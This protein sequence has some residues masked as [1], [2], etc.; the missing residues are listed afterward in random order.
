M[1]DAGAPCPKSKLSLNDNILDHPRINNNLCAIE[2]A[3]RFYS[4]LILADIWKLYL[5]VKL[6]PEFHDFLRFL[7][8]D[9]DT[10][11]DKIYCFRTLIWGVKDS[12][13][14]AINVIN[15]LIDMAK[16]DMEL[17]KDPCFMEKLGKQQGDEERLKKVKHSFY[18]DDLALSVPSVEEGRRIIEILQSV[19]GE[20]SL[21]LKKFIS[22]SSKLLETIPADLREETEEIEIDR[23]II[24]HD[25]SIIS[26]ESTLL[27]Y[28]YRPKNDV[29]IFE[30]YADMPSAYS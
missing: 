30:K 22:N 12:G 24:G 5:Q 3:V 6:K 18:V 8:K 19:L 7:W 23:N 29:Y 17:K 15:I 10:M 16:K 27:G 13:F 2:M 1:F 25:G 4:I 14:Q 26:K 28:S 20:G 11:E 21:I 9:P